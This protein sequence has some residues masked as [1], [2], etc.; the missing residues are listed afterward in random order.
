MSGQIKNAV[1]LPPHPAMIQCMRYN[2]SDELYSVSV[3]TVR[4]N[5]CPIRAKWIRLHSPDRVGPMSIPVRGGAM[6]LMCLNCSDKLYS[7]SVPFSVQFITS[8]ESV[9]YKLHLVIHHSHGHL[10]LE[11]Q[12]SGRTCSSRELYQNRVYRDIIRVG[13]RNVGQLVSA[14]VSTTFQSGLA[15]CHYHQPDTVYALS[16]FGQTILSQQ[17]VRMTRPRYGYN[18]PSQANSIENLANRLPHK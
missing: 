5:D 15:Q 11:I 12:I 7:V 3:S 6:S 8:S 9:S 16:L 13:A 1:Q 14:S 17:F 4:T 2:C 10:R 18:L